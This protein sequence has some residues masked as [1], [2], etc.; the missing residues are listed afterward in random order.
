[1]TEEHLN[2]GGDA[3]KQHDK[4][5]LVYSRKPKSKYMEN[6]TTEAP[7]ESK[8]MVAPEPQNLV[9]ISEPDLPIAIRKQPRSCTIHPI[10]KFMSYNTL[11]TSYRAFTTHLDNTPIPKTVQEALEIPH[12]R[13]AVME[14]MRALEKNGTWVVM[15]LPKERN[16]LDANGSSI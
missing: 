8:L 10:S 3:E 5:I 1:L 2:S 4:E 15:D 13:E 14:E 7:R 12:W 16:P 9:E 6:L 11:S